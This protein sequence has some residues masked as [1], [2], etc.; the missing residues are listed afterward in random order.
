MM[1]V[2]K[3]V[4]SR[5]DAITC[6]CIDTSTGQFGGKGLRHDQFLPIETIVKKCKGEFW[7]ITKTSLLRNARFNE[8][9]MGTE[10]TFWYQID[11]RAN[12]YYLHQALRVWDTTHGPSISHDLNKMDRL[13]MAKIYRPLADEEVYWS[14]LKKYAPVKYSLKSLKGLL[15]MHLT[16]NQKDAKKYL[17]KMTGNCRIAKPIGQLTMLIPRKIL[18]KIVNLV[19]R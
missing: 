6:N 19:P 18:E 12:R 13:A 11:Q 4:D 15:L 17:D 1:M 9:L 2:P 10:D 16:N 3:K 8:E 5:I 7:G 14:V